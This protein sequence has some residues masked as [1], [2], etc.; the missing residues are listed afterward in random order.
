MR[1][2]AIIF[3]CVMCIAVTLTIILV[4]LTIGATR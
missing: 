1:A 4:T 3:L 2:E